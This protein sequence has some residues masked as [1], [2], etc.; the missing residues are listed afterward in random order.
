[1]LEE[2]HKQ[3]VIQLGFLGLLYLG[4]L[5]RPFHTWA[6]NPLLY[7]VQI[8]LLGSITRVVKIQKF[9]PGSSDSSLAPSPSFLHLLLSIASL[10]SR[11]TPPNLIVVAPEAT[12]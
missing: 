6:D 4:H 11:Q 5:H 7:K 2:L 10:L 1:M 12:G 3:K 9:S 8:R